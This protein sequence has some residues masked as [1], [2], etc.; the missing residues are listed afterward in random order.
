MTNHF[1]QY[2]DAGTYEGITTPNSEGQ[3]EWV[4]SIYGLDGFDKENSMWILPLSIGIIA[5]LVYLALRPTKSKLERMLNTPGSHSIVTRSSIGLRETLLPQSDAAADDFDEADQ[6][7]T[8]LGRSTFDVQWYR[9]NTGE[10][11]L[12]KGCRLLFRKLHYS[13]PSKKGTLEI[14]KGV[15]GRAQPG[16]MCALM[17]ASGAGKSTLLDIL[18]GRK[19]VG[20]IQGKYY[21]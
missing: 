4:L 15:S 6:G 19:T 18:A 10:I 2:T 11:Q 17:G 9:T 20:N 12:S 13:V 3:G 1:E 8:L 21:I 7:G 16:E 14:L 5:F